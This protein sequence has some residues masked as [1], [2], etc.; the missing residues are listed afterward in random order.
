[1]VEVGDFELVGTGLTVYEDDRVIEGP[2]RWLDSPAA[3][4]DFVNSGRAGE[5]IVLA[6]GGTTT[7][8]S[9]ALTTGVKGVLTLQGAPESHLGILSREYGIPCLMSVAFSSGVRSSRGEIIPADGTI[10]RMDVSGSPTGRV[11][12]EPGAATTDPAADPG[13]GPGAGESQPSAE[14]QAQVQ[15]LLHNY[16]GETPHGSAGDQ[17]FRQRIGTGVLTTG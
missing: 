17:L 4:I 11:Y 6:R 9:P 13:S 1:M 3:V 16:L 15:H 5:S 12:A 8:L 7:F 14:E 10:V 2:V